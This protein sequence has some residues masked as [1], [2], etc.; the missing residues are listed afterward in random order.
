[1]NYFNIVGNNERNGVLYVIKENNSLKHI[2]LVIQYQ[3]L[4]FSSFYFTS[5]VLPKK[6]K[7]YIKRE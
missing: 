1:M 3:V 6:K 7:S 4:F 5:N 2:S